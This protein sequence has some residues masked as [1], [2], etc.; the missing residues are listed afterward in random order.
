MRILRSDRLQIVITSNWIG[1]G[2]HNSD[3]PTELWPEWPRYHVV[4]TSSFDLTV[5]AH[6]RHGD[7]SDGGY[8]VGQS[9]H[10]KS[11]NCRPKFNYYRAESL[12]IFLQNLD[13]LTHSSLTHDPREPKK[14]QTNNSI[15]SKNVLMQ[16]MC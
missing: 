10:Q 6:G 15:K 5:G 1:D 2:K 14:K 4:D 7:G 12:S 9:D 8:N 11:L 13:T 16:R 3:G